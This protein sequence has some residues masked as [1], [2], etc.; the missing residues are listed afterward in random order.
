MGAELLN[1]QGNII[2]V[3]VVRVRRFRISWLSAKNGGEKLGNRRTNF[4]AVGHD[5]SST[6]KDN[7]ASGS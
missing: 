7:R 3:R 5:Y 1:I 6:D 4:A 2:R